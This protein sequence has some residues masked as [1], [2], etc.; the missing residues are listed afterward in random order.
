M[1][2]DLNSHEVLPALRQALSEARDG[3]P[4]GARADAIRTLVLFMVAREPPQ[5]ETAFRAALAD[6]RPGATHLRYAQLLTALGHSGEARFQIEQTR[7]QG[8]SNAALEAVRGSLL[9]RDGQFREAQQAL[10]RALRAEDVLSTRLLLARSLIAQDKNTDALKVLEEKI[11]SFEVVPWMA[12]ARLRAAGDDGDAARNRILAMA[13]RD[14]VGYTGA[15]LLL[16]AG[17]SDQAM[18][19]L[20]QLIRARDPDVIWL[21]VDP[22]WAPVQKESRFRERV[23]RVLGQ[24]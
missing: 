12:Y 23:G 2:R 21:G 15:L 20:D 17:E 8:V 6:D 9:F 7:G 14:N 3:A 5:A 13:A 18:T 1:A 24:N 16:E 10:E 19:L 11:S 22:E 4:T